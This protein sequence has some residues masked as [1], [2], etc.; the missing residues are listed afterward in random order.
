MKKGGGPLPLKYFNSIELPSVS[1]GRNFLSTFGNT[2]RSALPMIGGKIRK[3]NKHKRGKRK[4]GKSTT[5]KRKTGRKRGGFVP[6]VMGGF[7][8]AASKYIVPIALF[9]GY[10]L[11]TKKKSRTRH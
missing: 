8:E 6:S 3:R 10:K 5:G 9:S 1:S 4:T 11:M 2:V 7:V